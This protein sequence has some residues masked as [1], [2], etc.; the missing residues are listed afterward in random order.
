MKLTKWI[1]ALV[2]LCTFTALGFARQAP[3]NNLR[4]GKLTTIDTDTYIDVNNIKMWVTN[5]GSF[6]WDVTTG[7]PGL[8]FP[9]GTVNTVVFA[10]G[11]WVGAKVN[12]EIRIALSE[13]SDEYVPGVMEDS[14]FSDDQ[15]GFRV[16][17]I[18]RGDGPGVTDWDEWPRQ[19]GAPVE[20]VNGDTVPK[21]FGDQTL[22]TVYNDADASAHSN[23]AGATRPLGV[24]IQQ[25]SFG[26]NRSGALGNTIFLKFKIINKGPN[27]LDSAYI[28][29]WSDPDLGDASDDLVGCDT[30]LSVGYCYNATNSDGLYGASPPCV[31]Y[32]FFQGP[33]V[34]GNPTDTAWVSGEPR[35]GFKNLPMT[36]FNKYINGTDPTS[37]VD[38]YNYMKGL[39]AVT[40]KGAPYVNPVTGDTTTFAMSGDP[41]AGTGWLDVAPDDRRFMM[42]SGPFTM[43]PGDTQEVVA[44][45]VVGQGPDRLSSISTMKNYDTQAQAVFDLNFKIPSPPPQPTVWYRAFDQAIDLIWDTKADGD[46]Q[47]SPELHQEFV[48][49]GYNVYQGASVSGPWKKI[50]AFDYDDD[51]GYI[52]MDMFNP[53]KGGVE[54]TL[55]QAGTN[56]GLKYHLWIDKDW[57]RG[58]RLLNGH[59]YYFAVTAYSFDD[60][61]MTAYYLGETQ[62]GWISEVLENAFVPVLTIP[63]TSAATLIDTAEHSSGSSDGIVTIEY[64]IQDEVTGHDYRV[65]FND[66]D[67]WNLIDNTS[68]DT[69]LADQANQGDNY[70]YKI[71][72]GV[73]VRAVGPPIDIKSAEQVEGTEGDLTLG[74]SYG[75]M[76]IAF[77][78][79]L[80]PIEGYISD[81]EIRFVD[82]PTNAWSWSDDVTPITGGVPFEVWN[83]TTNVQV[84]CE[85]YDRG[86]SVWNIA[87]KDYL[88]IVNVPYDGNPHPEA[89]P[90]YHIWFFRFGDTDTPQ[91]GDVFRIISNKV[92]T[93]ED[94]FTFKTY[95]PGERKGTVVANTLDMVR[96]VPNPYFNSS[97]YEP[98]QF[99]RV[100]KFI[101]LPQANCTIRIFNLAGDLIRILKKDDPT[102]AI[103][104]W[105]LKTKHGLPVASGIYIYYLEAEGLGTKYGKMAIFTEKERLITY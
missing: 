80:G 25:T 66:D 62:L 105:D 100:L 1:L 33:I 11:L 77:E 78:E 55:V 24:E 61:N 58:G 14:T 27:V 23:N 64:L 82:T 41:V 72:D 88:I 56:N 26:F 5:T 21:F 89:Y 44:A 50:A 10:S 9:K 39:D 47:Y 19:D 87:D 98:D 12:G 84:M 57:I 85:I 75:A 6:A 34:P 30:A 67:T 7:N 42:C 13:Y 76:G 71:V 70:D 18:N 63:L 103:L 65:T 17:K 16:Y 53:D 45:I 2:L 86:D 48:M 29:L 3:N 95:K 74:Y 4:L 101:N 79:P 36:A 46:I 97:V 99:S 81:Y 8:I 68:N 102:A 49:Q 51:V 93:T 43:Q 90:D 22:W 37:K 52:Y 104:E 91:T 40:G 54:R 83:I 32:D 59:P 96:A 60:S 73:M 15:P 38:T 35:P 20:V 92:N 31:G 69:V 94:E 28:A